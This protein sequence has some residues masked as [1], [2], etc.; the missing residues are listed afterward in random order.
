MTWR[1]AGLLAASVATLAIGLRV[2]AFAGPEPMA[3]YLAAGDGSQTVTLSDGSYARLAQGSR[4]GHDDDRPEFSTVSWLSLSDENWNG[5]TLGVEGT[6]EQVFTPA[7]VPVPA[8]GL[9]LLTGLAGLA[10]LRRKA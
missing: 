10:A 1:A 7:P 8:A 6:S 2:V 9:L 4:L 5:F 3:T